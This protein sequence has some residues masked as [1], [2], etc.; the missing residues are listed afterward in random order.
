MR[1]GGATARPSGGWSMSRALSRRLVLV[2]L[3]SVAGLASPLLVASAS[4]NP[5]STDL[6]INE[7]YVNGGSSGAS[8]VN[9]FVELYNPTSSPVPLT[10]DTLQY[11]APTSTVVPS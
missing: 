5:S 8:F 9:K 11:R 4:A 2:A 10:G 6:V 1:D 7:A 3:L